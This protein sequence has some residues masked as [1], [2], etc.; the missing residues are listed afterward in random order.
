ME[1]AESPPETYTVT[2]QE[3]NE[4]TISLA[5]PKHQTLG[6]LEDRIEE[7]TRSTE[8][9]PHFQHGQFLILVRGVIINE[10]YTRNAKLQDI[11]GIDSQV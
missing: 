3:P 11:Q 10:Q 8:N 7:L 9:W 2:L 1:E 6:A 5:F 4:R